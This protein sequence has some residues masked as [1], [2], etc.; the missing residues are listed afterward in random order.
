MQT[1]QRVVGFRRC[2]QDF[3]EDSS[4][5]L[6]FEWCGR[7][8]FVKKITAHLDIWSGS[9]MLGVLVKLGHLWTRISG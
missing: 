5:N 7:R 6:F 1:V 8:P 3:F 9:A 4:E 2:L